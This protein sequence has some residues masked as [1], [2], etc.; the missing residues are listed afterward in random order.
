MT[1]ENMSKPETL[2]EA[3]R[4]AIQDMTD[5]A[6]RLD[7]AHYLQSALERE[8]TDPSVW[9]DLLDAAKRMVEDM[10]RDWERLA[11]GG[12]RGGKSGHVSK[13]HATQL[14][15]K[16]I[17]ATEA[18]PVPAKK[19]DVAM[20]QIHMETRNA[21]VDMLVWFA[22][23]KAPDDRDDIGDDDLLAAA[24]VACD[25]PAKVEGPALSLRWDGDDL[26]LGQVWPGSAFPSTMDGCEGE[27]SA[28]YSVR[29][30]TSHDSKQEAR[31]AVE[32]RA[33]ELIGA[34]SVE[35]PSTPPLDEQSIRKDE[36]ERWAKVMREHAGRWDR[37]CDAGPESKARD[38]A[39]F[40]IA[41]AEAAC[42]LER[43]DPTALDDEA[44]PA[45]PTETPSCSACR[46]GNHGA[47]YE[48]S[49]QS[50]CIC[51]HLW[52]EP[53]RLSLADVDAIWPGAIVGTDSRFLRQWRQSGGPRTVF[54]EQPGTY[55]F[56]FSKHLSSGS[57][58]Y[59]AVRTNADVLALRAWL[60]GTETFCRCSRPGTILPPDQVKGDES[61][62]CAT[63]QPRPF[64]T[65]ARV[66]EMLREVVE[67]CIQAQTATWAEYNEQYA[68][69]GLPIDTSRQSILIGGPSY[70]QLLRALDTKEGK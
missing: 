70:A 15:T 25:A 6:F 1:A 23:F 43:N 40:Q 69:A 17:H 45:P 10:E 31:E 36:R 54:L 11:A 42:A 27:W 5:H 56:T 37:A 65:E 60:E 22:D 57:L 68:G 21:L 32:K 48:Q 51:Q 13:W 67:A 14:L 12:G 7:I 55:P 63:E 28:R 26:R 53:E 20:Q 38:R 4:Y 58:T 3:V 33:R 30:P 16:A 2:R 52:T 62:H 50:K 39:A 9:L 41:L 44:A 64:V 47:C 59:E 61:R 66:L 19:W 34:V 46:F 29:Q 8:T 18:A 24:K 49:G 35:T